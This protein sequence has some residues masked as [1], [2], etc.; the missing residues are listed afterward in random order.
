[1]GMVHITAELGANPAQ[2]TPLRFLVDTGSMY[3]FVTP[4]LA[5]QLGVQFTA[6]TTIITGNSARIQVPL[7][8]AYMRV[9]DRENAIVLGALDVPE[10]VLGALTLQILGLKVDP[11]NEILEHSRP[12][13]D[14]PLLTAFQSPPT[15]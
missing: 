12:Y 15:F 8:F 10:P 5:E 11:V 7:A 4:E 14:I 3:S 2:L 1:M 13:N 9:L 6:S